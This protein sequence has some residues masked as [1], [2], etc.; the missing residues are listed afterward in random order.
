VP[1]D[2]DPGLEATT[3]YDPANYTYPFG[4][5]VAVVEVDPDTGAFEIEQFQTVDDVGTQIN[6]KLVEG[7]IHGG[8]AQGIGQA[9]L[10]QTSYDE[11]GNL[12]SGSLQDYAVP[13][14]FH[15]P[16]LATESTV[17]EAPHNPLGAKG[18]GEAGAIGAP[19]A[20]VN[21][22]LDALEPF[23]VE[24]VDMPLTDETVWRAIQDA[25]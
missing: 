4:T 2:L 15:V 1:D 22:V 9:R 16:E 10:E 6:P 3:Y 17:T 18:V 5:Y 20:L 19:A 7:Q 12:L 25:G 13:K 24:H 23:G 8:V 11:N 21:A 14:A